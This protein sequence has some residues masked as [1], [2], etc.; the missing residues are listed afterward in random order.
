MRAPN[1]KL[2]ALVSQDVESAGA[3]NVQ[4]LLEEQLAQKY[5]YLRQRFQTAF[6][7][8]TMA[9]VGVIVALVIVSIFNISGISQLP[10][11][12]LLYETFYEW[13]SE[14]ATQYP[15]CSWNCEIAV[16]STRLVTAA[17][18]IA[19]S[20]ITVDGRGNIAGMARLCTLVTVLFSVGFAYRRQLLAHYTINAQPAQHDDFATMPNW[21]RW[22]NRTLYILATAFGTYV[23]T[24]VLW[25]GL[26][27]VFRELSLNWFRSGIVIV[28]F[29]GTI[30]FIATYV[31]LAASTRTV[32]SLGLFT[33]AAG[34]ALSFALVPQSLGHQWWEVAVSN[35][36]QFNP[37]ASLFTG[38]LL[39]GSLA[40]VIIWFDMDSI[41][42]KMIDDGDIQILSP[43]TWRWIARLLY[44]ALILGLLLIAFIRVDQDNFPLNMVFHAGGSLAAIASTVIAGL[45]I[46]KKRFHPWYHIFTVYILLGLTLGMSILGSLKFDPFSLVFPGT[47]IISLVVIELVLFVLMGLWL[48][49]T[50][51]NLL[52]QANIH[53]FDGQVLV[54]M[55]QD[56]A[57]SSKQIQD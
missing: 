40:L 53:A 29:T 41:I 22:L 24:S 5:D 9:T 55:Q 23:L 52:G 45:L 51:D 26:A 50:A 35:A 44:F 25:L 15:V 27:M 17:S 3:P 31:A 13:R 7:I 21:Q 36:G 42:H 12:Y 47:G 30:T 48:Y 33:L 37:S 56:N 57:Q 43:D 14:G 46:R 4:Q 28:L 39:S 38:T 11:D 34:F 18:E 1:L 2:I 19:L 6:L 32:L 20:V 10:D 16:Q 54:M 49:L 8:T